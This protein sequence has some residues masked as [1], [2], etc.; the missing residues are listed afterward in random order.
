MSRVSCKIGYRSLVNSINMYNKLVSIGSITCKSKRTCRS[1]SNINLTLSR[2]IAIYIPSSTNITT[3]C[4]SHT[5]SNSTT[6][7]CGINTRSNEID[8]CNSRSKL[9]TFVQNCNICCPTRTCCSGRP[10]RASCPS[11][12][13]SSCPN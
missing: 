2:N 12:P 8:T 7:Y 11:R 3:T 6:R 5:N 10:C 13:Q 4:G 1:V 9:I